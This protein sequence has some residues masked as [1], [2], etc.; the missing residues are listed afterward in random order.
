M[1][2]DVGDVRIGVA[3]SE[4]RV[5]ATTL[6]AIQ[7]TGR[8]AVLDVLQGLVQ[9]YGIG[10]LV[11]GIPFLEGGAEGEQVEKTRAFVRSLTRR[12]PRL[13]VVEWDERHTSSEARGIL[14]PGRHERGRVDSV[15]AAVI[16]QEYL[17]QEAAAK[18]A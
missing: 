11:V 18:D 1:A 3:V 13:R 10:T 14:G 12:L 5:I 8:K 17:D 7:R 2:L 16:L 4:S 15:A 6:P 9:Q